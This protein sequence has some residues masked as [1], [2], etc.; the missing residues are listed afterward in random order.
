MPPGRY[1]IIVSGNGNRGKY[2]LAVGEREAWPLKETLHALRVIPGLK[3]NF[4]NVSPAMFAL[5]IF[6]GI[7]LLVLLLSGV[8]IGFLYRKV[9]RLFSRPVSG[10][11]SKNIG[12]SGRVLRFVIAIVLLTWAVTTAWNPFLIIVSGFTFFEALAGWCGLYAALG[13]KSCRTA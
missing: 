8:L 11:G 2:A 13:K 12:G 6:G 4:F 7:Y 1:E 5:S 9:M 10:R 3:K